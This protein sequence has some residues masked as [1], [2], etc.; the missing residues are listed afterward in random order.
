MSCL[1][2]Q[3]RAVTLVDLLV[4][5]TMLT[6]LLVGV[7][8]V[9]RSADEWTN[10]TECQNNLKQIGLA[11]R[12]Y[13]TQNNGQ[14]PRC[15]AATPVE[16]LTDYKVVWGTPYADL[17]SAAP[18]DRA[19][20]FGRSRDATTNSSFAS[21]DNDVT[22]ALYLLVRT[23]DLPAELFICPSSR[24]Q[25]WGFVKPN[26]SAV[27]K[28][29][30]WTN[31]PG[32]EGIARH[33]SYSVQNMYPAA[34]G[35][36]NGF[37]WNGSKV[38]AAFVI[39]SDMNPGSDEVL[40]VRRQSSTKERMAANSLNHRGQGQNVLCADGHVDWA[41]APLAGVNRDNIFTAR[42]SAF[43][44]EK[45]LEAKPSVIVGP[46][47]DGYDSVMLPTARDIG[48]VKPDGDKPKENGR[49]IDE[50]R[51]MIVGK[52][53][54]PTVS[55][56]LQAH[57]TIDDQSLDWRAGPIVA[58]FTYTV[59]GENEVGEILLTVQGQGMPDAPARIS[60]GDGKM[61]L[62]SDDATHLLSTEWDRA[63]E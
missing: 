49:P 30:H 39:A 57:L 51:K 52:Y 24:L 38:P 19:D 18:S 3:R 40:Q 16:K 46:P 12:V 56:D 37:A 7:V 58:T 62:D 48:F 35:V 59:Q 29:E 55:A 44:G 4:V 45:T 60:F 20:P 47:I 11:F 21:S 5:L 33:L 31:W 6:L 10:R 9:R 61:T 22:A 15:I 14:Y 13:E 27:G 36:T 53:V 50:L 42:T 25:P 17:R 32:N 34:E 63:K 41:T 23:Q 8:G 28:P 54:A 2:R 26:S 1:G 43:R